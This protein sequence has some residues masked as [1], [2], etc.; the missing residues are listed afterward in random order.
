MKHREFICEGEPVL[1]INEQEHAAFLMNIEQS[2]LLSLKK[3][4]LLTYSQYERCAEA[5]DKQHRRKKDSQA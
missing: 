1:Q 5:L 4:N 2:I 3:R